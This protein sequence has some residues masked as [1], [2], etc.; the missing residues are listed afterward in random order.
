MMTERITATAARKAAVKL[1]PDCPAVIEW[2]NVARQ[3]VSQ[4]NRAD[5]NPRTVGNSNAMVDR[6]EAAKRA[7]PDSAAQL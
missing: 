4:I 3:R 5:A 6:L 2:R 1:G 7:M